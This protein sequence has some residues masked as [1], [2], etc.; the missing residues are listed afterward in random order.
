MVRYIFKELLF[1][2][3]NLERYMLHTDSRVV[4]ERL[5][6]AFRHFMLYTPPD[7]VNRCLRTLLIEYIGHNKDFLSPEFDDWMDDLSLLF[8]L[9]DTAAKET[10]GWYDVDDNEIQLHKEREEGTEAHK[11]NT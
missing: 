1:A 10:R 9:L 5:A 7:R 6:E 8:S 4:S 3:V 11:E 2:T